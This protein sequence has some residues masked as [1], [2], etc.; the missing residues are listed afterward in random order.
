M[1]TRTIVLTGGPCSGKTTAMSFISDRLRSLGFD[2]FIVPEAATMLI[3]GGAVLVPENEAHCAQ[4][5]A[6]LMRTQIHHEN[7]FHTLAS[8]SDKP[9]VIICDRGMMDGYAFTPSHIWQAILDENGWSNVGLRD[10]HYDAVIHMVTAAN[11]AEKFYT[12]ANNAARTE[13]PDQAFVIDMKIQNAWLGHP[14]LRVV[15]NSTGF[16]E[17]VRRVI[18]AVCN[19][20]GVPEPVERERKFLV[21]SVGDFG[22]VRA[23]TVEIEQRYLYSASGEIARVRRRG[24]NGHFTYTHTVKRYLGPGKNVEIERIVSGREYLTLLQKENVTFSPVIKKR[25]CFIW[26]NQYFELDSFESPRAGLMLLE[27]EIDSDDAEVKL[28]PFIKIVREVTEE[29]EFSNAQIA[30]A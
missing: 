28:P 16:D 18:A 30:A 1:T 7:T 8:M 19:V 26:E 4:T 9:S 24:Q 2:V 5:Q 27:A 17:K 25:T 29:K 12:L 11:G 14:H 20:V 10:K 22:E 21:E 15:D 3:L 13:T 23:E 6:L